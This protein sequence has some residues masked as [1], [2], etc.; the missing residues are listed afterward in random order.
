MALK[1]D[2]YSFQQ[3]LSLQCV[4]NHHQ[5]KV[6]IDRKSMARWVKEWKAWIRLS[7]KEKKKAWREANRHRKIAYDHT[8]RARKQGNPKGDS[9]AVASFIRSVRSAKDVTCYWCDQPIVG[10][11]HID[12]IVPI[13]RGGA[14]DVH[15]LCASCHLCNGSKS[16]WLPHEWN[17]QMVFAFSPASPKER[18]HHAIDE[19]KIRTQE[20]MREQQE[21][22]YQ[23]KLRRDHLVPICQ[24]N[25]VFIPLTKGHYALIDRE[26]WDRVKMHKWSLQGDRPRTNITG[27]TVLLGSFIT[28]YK[29]LRR[30]GGGLD[31]RRSAFEYSQ[32]VFGYQQREYHRTI[33]GPPAEPLVSGAE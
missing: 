18:K 14:D 4:N 22:E 32:E 33:W 19:E 23:R 9:H 1:I 26:D 13:A 2:K 25:T 10:K 28:G 20:I 11:R 31:Y 3:F 8:R 17:K 16:D 15:N 6:M 21:A 5:N 12:H 27:K 7:P 29:Y 24:G 30:K